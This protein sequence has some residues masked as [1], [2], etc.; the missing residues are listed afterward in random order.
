MAY[1]QR[2]RR[3]YQTAKEELYL[4]ALNLTL[5][6]HLWTPIFAASLRTVYGNYGEAQDFDQA[7]R[8][9]GDLE[10]SQRLPYG[11]EFTAGMISTLIR[12]VGKTITA[13]EQSEVVLGLTVPLLRGAG[14]VAQEN[15]IQLER[16]LTYSVRTFERYR[17][18][19]LVS[20]ARAYFNLLRYKQAV[21]D[22]QD[23]LERA[24]IDFQRAQDVEEL[25]NG[26]PLDTQRAEQRMLSQQNSL[27][28]ARESFRALADDFKILI[29][30]PVDEPLGLD[31]LEN[32]EIIE[33]Q[34]ATGQYPLLRRVPAVQNEELAVQVALE[35]RFDLLTSC[36]R[37]DDARRDVAISRNALLPD[38]NWSGSVRFDTQD[39]HYNM[40]AFH[41]ERANWYTELEL[42]LPVER[43]AERNELRRSLIEVR[44]TQ[45]AATDLAERIR[46]D[47]RSAVNQLRLQEISLRIQKRNVEVA[48]SRAEYAKY[49]F[50]EI[51]DISNRD[52]IE[53]ET[54]LLDALNAL[55]EAKT[56]RWSALLEFRLA[57]ETLQID[58]QG[59]QSALPDIDYPLPAPPC[60]QNLSPE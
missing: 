39:D 47:V 24:I 5:E 37:I 60:D 33:R 18:S 51:G 4:A 38:L 32:I 25:P 11:G 27:E 28:I 1:A 43:T 2:H 29:G 58:E 54:E 31:D 17:R 50:E 12:D 56:A 35:R 3:A 46:A 49:R 22:S 30:M 19:Q 9:V 52:K 23:S 7:M 57:T 44:Q 15:L 42:E 34:I 45:R 20:V 13:E 59:E 41:F 8:F 21:L 6:R 55:N 40:G 53:A 10:V 16:E 36:D 26:S 14:H 48:R